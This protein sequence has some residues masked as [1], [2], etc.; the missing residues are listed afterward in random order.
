MCHTRKFSEWLASS[1][2]QLTLLQTEETMQNDAKENILFDK[3]K[4]LLSIYAS[5][6]GEEGIRKFKINR[7]HESLYGTYQN[8]NS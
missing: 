8:K 5:A 1:G 3:T 6:I 2:K 7:N 4:D